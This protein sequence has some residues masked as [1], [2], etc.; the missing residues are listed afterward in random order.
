MIPQSS[1]DAW[2]ATAPWTR[3]LQVEQDLIMTR[4]VAELFADDRVRERVAVRGGTAL[5][6]LYFGGGSRYSEDIDLVKITAGKAGPLFDL[7]REK[8]DSW[9]GKPKREVSEASIKLFYRF[10]SETDPVVP[11]RLKVEVNMVEN[12]SVLGY[13]DLPFSV[14]SSWFAGAAVVRT[15]ALNELLGT[16]IRAL[17]QRRKGR[18]LFDLWYALVYCDC[19]Q[20][21]ITTCFAKYME[22][23]G[24]RIRRREL[25]TNL[26][27]KSSDRRF[28]TDV[29]PLIR[30][31]LDYDPATAFDLIAERLIF[32]IPD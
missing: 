23:G 22:H 21:Q 28:L 5:N 25:L 14:D 26:Q 15:F 29:L 4:A 17:Y 13:Q 32:L 3:D 30:T 10:D 2:R 6:K 12:F 7:I 24:H 31:G 16:K 9:L 20:Q 11:M 27:E 8:L 1:I 19:D 18:D